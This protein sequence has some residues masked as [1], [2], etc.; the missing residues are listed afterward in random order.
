MD[1]ERN[2]SRQQDCVIVDTRL[3]LIDIGS[4]TDSIFVAESVVATIEIKSS[5]GTSELGRYFKICSYNQKAKSNGPTVLRE[6]RH[7]N[8]NAKG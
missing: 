2:Q 8:N 7:R 1:A 5:L 6:S 3:P 4:D